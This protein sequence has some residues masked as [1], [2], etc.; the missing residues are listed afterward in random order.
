[1]AQIILTNHEE[2][3]YMLAQDPND[4]KKNY[5]KVLSMKYLM[6]SLIINFMR[7][8]IPEPK[9]EQII[10][11]AFWEREFVTCFWEAEITSTKT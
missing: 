1:M 8:G 4:L 11:T 9:I 2:I 5:Y 3:L 10:E 7:E 6:W